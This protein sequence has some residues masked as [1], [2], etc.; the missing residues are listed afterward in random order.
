MNLTQGDHAAGSVKIILAILLLVTS[1]G[2]GMTAWVLLRH[3]SLLRDLVKKVEEGQVNRD[4]AS[5]GASASD[6]DKTSAG[7]RQLNSAGEGFNAEDGCRDLY[8]RIMEEGGAAP[9]AV[10][11]NIQAANRSLT[12]NVVEKNPTPYYGQPVVIMGRIEQVREYPAADGSFF[13]D[14]L[15]YWNNQPAMVSLG[16][17]TPFVKD[18]QVTV[19]GYLAKHLY[20]YKSIAQWDMAVPLVI[21]RAIIKPAEARNLSNSK[22]K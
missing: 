14:V 13:T 5:N 22:P 7:E 20:R 3:E 4:G 9:E 12:Y 18:D 15:V 21:A 10:A 11:K 6:A 8:R 1:A 17:H 19:V 16:E 2:F